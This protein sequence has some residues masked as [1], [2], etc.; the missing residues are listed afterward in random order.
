MWAKVIAVN[1]H[2]RPMAQTVIEA[3][4][5]DSPST[6]VTTAS[7]TAI[8]NL[9]GCGPIISGWPLAGAFSSTPLSAKINGAGGV[10]L[11]S[12]GSANVILNGIELYGS[13]AGAIVAPNNASM[14]LKLIN[15]Y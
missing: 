6:P 13:S 14:G 11:T 3:F 2:W 12:T 8:C 15:C 1:E 4:K 5:I 9:Q 10:A 7:N